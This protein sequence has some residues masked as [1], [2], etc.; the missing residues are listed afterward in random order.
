MAAAKAS[1][2]WNGA[3]ITVQQHNGFSVQRQWRYNQLIRDLGT[4]DIPAAD[5]KGIAFYLSCTV[6]CEGNPGFPVPIDS[7]T[8]AE[9]MAFI[10]GVGESDGKLIVLYDDTIASAKVASNDPDLLPAD[11]LSQKKEKTPASNSK[12]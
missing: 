3:K 4:E 1:F 7:A 9:L 5:A 6:A 2:E 10:R 8:H 12:D 11:E